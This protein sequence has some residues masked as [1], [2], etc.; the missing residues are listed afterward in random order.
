M[1]AKVIVFAIWSALVVTISGYGGVYLIVRD[2]K[3]INGITK[4]TNLEIFKTKTINVPVVRSSKVDGYLLVQ[5][6]YSAPAKQ[7]GDGRV[8]PEVYILDEAFR[9][10]YA[11]GK[12]IAKDMEKYDL[13]K[14]TKELLRRTRLRTGEKRVKEIF[15]QKFNFVAI[16]DVR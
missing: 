6:A 13:K 11:D 15:V 9:V 12:K 5:F 2:E 10:I 16:A 3:Q 7:K 4:K 8:S 14:L 1:M